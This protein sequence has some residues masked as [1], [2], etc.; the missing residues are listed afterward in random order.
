[1]LILLYPP[2]AMAC[3]PMAVFSRPPMLDHIADA[4]T[5]VLSSAPLF[6]ESAR[7]PIAVLFQPLTLEYSA[8]APLAVLSLPQVLFQSAAEPV[9]VL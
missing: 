9:A 4:P 8:P 7:E 3:T 2:C 6:W 1:M 5:A